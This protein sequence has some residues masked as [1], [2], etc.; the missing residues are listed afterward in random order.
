M[1]KNLTDQVLESYLKKRLVFPSHLQVSF[2]AE[3][4][5]T[6]VY[7]N[8]ISLTNKASFNTPLEFT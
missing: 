1:F 6:F 8:E 2:Y 3:H 4:L 7:G 5:E